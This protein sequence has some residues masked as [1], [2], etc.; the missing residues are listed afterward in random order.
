MCKRD[1]LPPYLFARISQLIAAKRAQGVDV[2]SF[3]IGDPDLPT[4][5][6]ILD[7]LKRAADDPT[8][9]RYPETEG[10]PEL[11]AAMAGWYRRRH[12]VE[13]DPAKEIV[14]L[15]GSKE[16]IGHLPPR[17]VDPGDVVLVTYPGYPVYEPL[18]HTHLTLP[19]RPHL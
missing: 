19:T 15:I 7:A 1:S 11:R 12:G 13:L 14:S 9:H 4:P 3:G 17:V 18:S 6:H 5:P 8:N 16:R 10:P 2:I